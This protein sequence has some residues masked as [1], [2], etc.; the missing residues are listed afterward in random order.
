MTM[1]AALYL[2]ISSDPRGEG[3]GVARQETDCRALCDRLGWDVVDVYTD[4]DVSAYRGHRRPEYERMLADIKI[5]R[6]NAIAAYA[7]DRLYRRLADLVS[8]MEFVRST[9][10]QIQTC[11]A[12]EIDLNTASGRQNAGHT[13]VAAAAEVDRLGERIRRKLAANAAEG[14][15]HGGKRPYGWETDRRTIIEA[16]AAVVRDATARVLAGESVR[17]IYRS[18]NARGVPNSM[19]N[20]WTH[21]TLRGV[22]L[23]P[24]NAGIRVHQGKEAGAGDWPPLLPVE[25][26]RALVRLLTSPDRVTTPGRGGVITLL[27][28]LAHCA[29][30]GEPVYSGR[31]KGVPIYRCRTN[32]HAVRSRE[33]LDAFVSDIMIERLSRDDA[34]DLLRPA[35]DDSGWREAGEQAE[36]LR[37]RLDAAAASFARGMIDDRQLAVITA[38]IRPELAELDKRA[39]PPPDRADVLG[40]IITATDVRAGWDR[41]G[42]ERQR[43]II[44]TLLADIK[45]GPGRRGPIWSPEGITIEWRT[46]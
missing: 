30:C 23:R 33:R 8:F 28:G 24:R 27:A 9:G 31:S 6:C 15:P 19:G 25:T 17:S 34:V 45:V 1:R 5:G 42:K 12:G 16:E 43:A 18:L 37:Q 46:S 22:L 40:D 10:C 41:Y 38:E 36:R 26:W 3:L 29:T 4:N 20:P 35:D 11:A 14:K 2:R 39:T 44:A 21:P 7:P 32:V 13:G